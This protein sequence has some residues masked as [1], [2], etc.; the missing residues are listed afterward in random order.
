MTY[1]RYLILLLFP[2][3][4]YGQCG[5]CPPAFEWKPYWGACKAER[6]ACF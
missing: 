1:L 6:T 4:A 2:V 5:L 3:I